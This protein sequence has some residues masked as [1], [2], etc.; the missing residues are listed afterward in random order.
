MVK[1]GMRLKTKSVDIPRQTFIP[2]EKVHKIRQSAKNHLVFG[3]LPSGPGKVPIIHKLLRFPKRKRT[4]KNPAGHTVI[5][6]SGIFNNISDNP[7]CCGSADNEE[8][9][10]M[11]CGAAIPEFSECCCKIRPGRRKPRK[12]IQ[13][14]DRF[15]VNRLPYFLSLQHLFQSEKASNQSLGIVLTASPCSLSL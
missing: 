3:N 12:F 8:I 7:R 6:T 5:Q 4:K 11:R 14:H 13:K 15:S 9:V 1:E 10:R 2:I